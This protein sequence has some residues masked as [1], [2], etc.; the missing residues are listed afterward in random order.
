LKFEDFSLSDSVVKAIKEIGLS[1]PTPIQEKA[2]P[3]LLSGI[4]LIG[5]AKTGTGKTFAFAIPIVEKINPSERVVQGIVLTPTRELAVQ[6]AKEFEKIGKHKRTFVVSIYGGQPIRKQLAQLSK[7]VHIVVG[8]PGRVIDHIKRRTLNLKSIRFTV[9][10]EADRMLD[11]G[12]IDDMKFILAQIPK[13]SQK[14][15]FS[16]TMPSQITWLAKRYMKDPVDL[17]LS[18]D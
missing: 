10:D 13:K 2:I 9:L 3:Q 18:K 8:T 11:M 14:M 15:M 4:D 1:T 7:G 16:A 6:V 5:Q 12:F 17:R